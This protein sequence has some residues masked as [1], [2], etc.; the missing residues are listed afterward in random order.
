MNYWHICTYLVLEYLYLFA[1][2][3]SVLICCENICTYLVLEY[4]LFTVREGGFNGNQDRGT[5][6]K[7]V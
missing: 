6:N 1:V 4:P 3:I 5:L 2:R 7:N